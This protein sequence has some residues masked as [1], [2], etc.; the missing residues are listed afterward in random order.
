MP[1][2]R[3]KPDGKNVKKCA[4]HSVPA[5][6]KKLPG[7]TP[8]GFLSDFKD[9]S[10]GGFVGENNALT[11]AYPF[12]DALDLLRSAYRSL[13]QV[14]NEYIKH[15]FDVDV[16]MNSFLR[17]IKNT[18]FELSDLGWLFMQI[19][20]ITAKEYDLMPKEV[21]SVFDTS[22]FCELNKA[23]VDQLT[24]LLFHDGKNRFVIPAGI[25][26]SVVK[27][28]FSASFAM[29]NEVSKHNKILCYHEAIKALNAW[30]VQNG[31][32]RVV[33]SL[34]PHFYQPDK[35]TML[36]NAL[37]QN[38]YTLDAFEVNYEYDLKNFTE[39]YEM[40]IDPKARQKLRAAIKKGL[41]FEK[42]EDLPIKNVQEGILYRFVFNFEEK[43]V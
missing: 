11:R 4:C 6:S 30:A 27:F 33:F 31:H 42:T 23:K 2:S 13:L 17:K 25:K 10:L 22:A 8:V 43:E 5:S 7:R 3:Q 39:P 20:E 34:P 18:S 35:T 36:A 21:C 1:Q 37:L 15:N 9:F 16:N 38:G 26:N 12:D 32:R 19:T 14:Q 29:L 28:P 24:Y 40:T 41:T